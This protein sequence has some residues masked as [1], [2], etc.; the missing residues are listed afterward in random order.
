MSDASYYYRASRRLGTLVA[1]LHSKV[2]FL[3]KQPISHRI[4]QYFVRTPSIQLSEEWN[5][6]EFKDMPESVLHII[7][8]DI[9][10][11]CLSARMFHNCQY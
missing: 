1:M 6:R 4:K 3:M 10:V 8:Y 7:K 9:Q 5:L 11:D 2:I